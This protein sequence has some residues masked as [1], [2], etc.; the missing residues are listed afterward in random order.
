[1]P[2]TKECVYYM[3]PELVRLLGTSEMELMFSQASDVF[4]F[5]FILNNLF[6]IKLLIKWGF[7]RTIWYE[8][9]CYEYPFT[10]SST[11]TVIFAIGNG[12]KNIS[13]NIQIPKEF[14]V[15][16]CLSIEFIKYEF[17]FIFY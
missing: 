15:N 17:S 12:L 3:A 16:F 2:I 14:K 7:N 5:G 4:S 11:E 9:F 1:M 8:L 13:P 6:F 10:S